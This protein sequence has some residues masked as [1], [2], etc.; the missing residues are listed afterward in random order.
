MI[1]TKDLL[2][3]IEENSQK[4][5]YAAVKPVKQDADLLHD[6][7]HHHGIP[8]VEDKDKL[9]TTLLYSRKHLPSYKPAKA[10]T[11][12]AH[13]DGVEVWPTKS[14]KNCLVL[15]LKSPSLEARHKK[16]MDKHEATYDF[17]KFKSH[18]SL[19]Y[20]IGNYDISKI[21]HSK[22][23]KKISLSHE[24]QEDLDTSGK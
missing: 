5:T 18:I 7:A 17:P 15:K 20:D 6:F 3:M 21:D 13:T 4:G 14:G 24:Y 11:H 22:L 12:E 2:Q 10:I 19:S 1:K 9:H 16:L 8:N 23:P